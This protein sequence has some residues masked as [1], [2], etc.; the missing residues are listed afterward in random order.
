MESFLNNLLDELVYNPSE[1][2]LFN[3]GFFLFFFFFVLIFNK[4]F[5]NNKRAQ[6]F[7]LLVESLYFYYKSSGIFF[8][9]VIISSIVDYIA[10]RVIFS[11]DSKAKKKIYLVLSLITNLG[12]LG[13]FKYTNFFI[14]TLNGIV[15]GNFET[16]DIFLPVGVS[17]F[18]FQT[19][20]VG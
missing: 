3:T 1:P 20:L 19:W 11:T 2:I 13:Y 4:L 16:L 18:T 12:I 8:I 9:L 17:F 6:V 7:F 14:E 10:G 15:L 5:V